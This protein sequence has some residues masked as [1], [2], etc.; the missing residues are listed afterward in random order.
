MG[1]RHDGPTAARRWA[2]FLT[3]AVTL[4]LQVCVQ[5]HLHIF[6]HISITLCACFTE[7]L[8]VVCCSVCGS[9]HVYSSAAGYSPRLDVFLLFCG[10]LH[11]LL[12]PLA[13]VC[14]WNAALWHV[15]ALGF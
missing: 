11:V 10:H 15:S 2:S 5:L 7:V 14:F 4:F 12:C 13:D 6:L 9:G 3:T 1:S 8:N